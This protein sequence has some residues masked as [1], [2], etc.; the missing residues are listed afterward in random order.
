MRKNFH[1]YEQ[2]LCAIIDSDTEKS[3]RTGGKPK[4]GADAE[5]SMF[6]ERSRLAALRAYPEGDIGYVSAECSECQVKRHLCESRGG[7]RRGGD[8]SKVVSAFAVYQCAAH[9]VW[10]AQIS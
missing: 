7:L 5:K 9:A 10:T 2:P 6:G 4:T 3:G 1:A 8:D